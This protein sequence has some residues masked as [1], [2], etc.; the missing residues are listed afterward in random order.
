MLFVDVARSE[1]GAVVYVYVRVSVCV[2]VC[3]LFI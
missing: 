1:F 2:C 3:V